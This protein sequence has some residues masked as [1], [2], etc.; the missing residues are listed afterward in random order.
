MSRFD[1]KALE[2]LKALVEAQPDAT[3]QELQER[4][5]VE[6]S[7]MAVHRALERLGCSRKKSRCGPVSKTAPTSRRSGENGSRTSPVSTRPD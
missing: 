5:N 4:S 1:D 7:I 2:T 6:G 3:L